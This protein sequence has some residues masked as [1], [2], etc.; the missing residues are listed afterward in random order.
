MKLAI[1]GG[2][3]LTSGVKTQS[4]VAFRNTAPYDNPSS[5]FKCCS[6]HFHNIGASKSSLRRLISQLKDLK[7]KRIFS[8]KVYCS[9]KT[10]DLYVS[11]YGL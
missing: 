3:R 4:R 10:I 6:E 8:E 9:L 7:D 2:R 11:L 5:I 1:E